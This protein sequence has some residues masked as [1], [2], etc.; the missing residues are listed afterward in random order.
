LKKL[1]DL[2][3]SCL[4]IV[5]AV[6]S[7]LT[8]AGCAPSA[9]QLKKVMEDNPDIMFNVIEKNPDKFL[10]VV[11]EAAQK[12][13]Q[14]EE[15]KM[16]EEE[17][18]VREEEYKN[19]KKPVIGDNR[20]IK[21][22]KAATITIVEYSDFQCPYCSR[23]YMTMKKVLETYPGKVKVIFKDAPIVRI[24]PNAMIASQYYEAVAVKQ[25]EKANE[26]HDYI[27][28]HQQELTEKG[29]TFLKAAVKKL[30]LK[31]TAKDVQSDEVKKRIDEDQ[32]EFEKFGFS[33]TPGY[34][35]NGIS[36]KGAYPLD[37]FKKIIDR[38][39][40]GT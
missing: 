1:N 23:G 37:E 15:Q 32:K 30:N 8:I 34:L 36:L 28:E 5:T 26:F 33:G 13:R 22:D 2:G 24:H 31:I 10:K 21:G 38:Q 35:V 14:V 19:P 16:Q 27:F 4:L 11:N 3:S 9:T 25:P 29:E 12:A 20:A 7:T 40:K 6:V 17:G 18:K 39:L